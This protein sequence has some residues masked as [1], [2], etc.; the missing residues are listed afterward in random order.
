MLL[1]SPVSGMGA[2]PPIL[3][4]GERAP[5]FDLPGVDGKRHR[6]QDFAAA[7][8]LVV[9]FTCNHCPTAQAYEG[10]IQ[11]L[12]D[13]FRGRKVALVAISP[14]DPRALRLDELGYSDM[15][16]TLEEM[17]IRARDR[18]FTFP[19]LYDGDDQKVSRAYGPAA[20]PHVFI[21]DRERRLRYAGRID[22]S[23]RPDKITLHDTRS[24][25]EA[26]LAGKPVPVE[27]TKTFGCSIKWSDKR[28][29][30]KAAL[31]RWA[32]EEVTLQKIDERGIRDL[33]RNDSGKVR[34]VNVWAT[35]CGPCIVEFPELV[36]IHRMYRGRNFELVTISADL[37][38]KSDEALAFLRKQQASSRNYIFQLDD[39]Y[40]LVEALDKEWPGALPFTVIVEPGGKILYRQLGEFS[41][42]DL[43]KAIV[44]R[45]GRYYF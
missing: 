40:K 17:K 22:D 26:L 25:I 4:I 1:L 19:Y 14:N 35:W 44:A 3:A 41:S 39:K 27:K 24:A 42:L 20:T 2:D 30:V 28:P 16:D 5:D 37:P 38:E 12:A 9:V 36:S 33:M 15:N 7:E 18:K 23:E 43:R 29:S 32:A 31:E 11:K 13:D 6:L 10:R 45:L 34:L 21:F 8:M